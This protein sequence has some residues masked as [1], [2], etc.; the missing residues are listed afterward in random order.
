MKFYNFYCTV[1]PAFLIRRV[2]TICPMNIYNAS[3]N[4]GAH[5]TN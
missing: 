1:E 2:G 5:L 3:W 4:I